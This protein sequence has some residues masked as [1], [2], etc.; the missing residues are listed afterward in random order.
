MNNPLINWNKSIWPLLEPCNQKNKTKYKHK[1]IA[2]FQQKLCQKLLPTK[3]KEQIQKKVKQIIK[4]IDEDPD[5][6]FKVLN[7]KSNQQ[8]KTIIRTDPITKQLSIIS[9]PTELKKTIQ[10][11]WQK[12]FDE[13]K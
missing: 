13:K 4:N 7:K 11:N 2:N 12:I 8:L 3:K 5:F 9:N 6:V 1:N 10:E